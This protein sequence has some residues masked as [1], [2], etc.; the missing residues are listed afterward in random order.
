MLTFCA[1]N[2]N[3]LSILYDRIITC[4]LESVRSSGLWSDLFVRV[5][6]TAAAEQT[7]SDLQAPVRN[8]NLETYKC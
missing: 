4:V 7:L 3:A 6:F 8:F 1:A 2:N 5:R